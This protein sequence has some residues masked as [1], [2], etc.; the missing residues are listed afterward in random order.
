MEAIQALK[1][2]IEPN[3]NAVTL[4]V[5]LL[6]A[7]LRKV[8]DKVSTAESQIN[9]LQAVTKRLEKQIQDLTKKQAEVAAKL[10]DQ[11]GRARCNKV[12]IMGVPEG[13]EGHSTE[14]FIEDLILNK[15]GP[16]QLSNYVTIEEHIVC[17]LNWV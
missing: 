16:K 10:E 4:D 6:R 2:N 3:I 9:R 7:D 1:S 15:L 5:N 17:K 12:R 8:T 13:A 14:M 11:E